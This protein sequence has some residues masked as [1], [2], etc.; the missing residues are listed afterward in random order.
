MLH[1]LRTADNRACGFGDHLPTDEAN[2]AVNPRRGASHLFSLRRIPVRTGWEAERLARHLSSR[3]SFVAQPTTIADDVGSD[4]YCTIFDILLRRLQWSSL[5]PHSLFRSRATVTG[6]RWRS[7][8]PNGK[9]KTRFSAKKC[10]N[11][12]G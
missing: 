1:D 5:G 8:T 11:L 6:G 12:D 10:H 4:F 3:F 7:P 2:C 9:G